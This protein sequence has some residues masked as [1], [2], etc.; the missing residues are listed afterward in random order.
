MWKG[1][2]HGGFLDLLHDDNA[3]TGY[4]STGKFL[5]SLADFIP[6]SQ[7]RYCREFSAK[8]VVRARFSISERDEWGVNMFNESLASALAFALLAMNAAISLSLPD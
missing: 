3:V 6:P 2:A 8:D 5:V 4:R 7:W 1:L